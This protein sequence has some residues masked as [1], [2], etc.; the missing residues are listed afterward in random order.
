MTYKCDWPHCEATTEQWF[1]D[2]WCS[3]A[4]DGD[5][6]KFLPDDCLLCPKHAEMFEEIVCNPWLLE[7]EKEP[8]R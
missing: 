7:R 6:I 5:D 1:T 2:G 4:N 3:A 8:A